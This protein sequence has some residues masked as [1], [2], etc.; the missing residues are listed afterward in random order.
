[1][2]VFQIGGGNNTLAASGGTTD[3]LSCASCDPD[4]DGLNNLQEYLTDTLLSI[5]PP[6]FASP[7]SALPQ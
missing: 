2:T 1:V 6:H 4:G 3:N 7:I 5:L